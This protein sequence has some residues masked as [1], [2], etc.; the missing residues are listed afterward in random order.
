MSEKVIYTTNT[1]Q[2]V[3]VKTTL[4]PGKGY[5]LDVV[6]INETTPSIVFS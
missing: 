2:N 4:Y 6:L 5:T 3:E 1:M